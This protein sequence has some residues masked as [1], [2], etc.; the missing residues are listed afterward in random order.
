MSTQNTRSPG[1]WGVAA[2]ALLVLA[3]MFWLLRPAVPAEASTVLDVSAARAQGACVAPPEE[4]RRSHPDLLR[5]QR[6]VTVR[7]G[8]RGGQGSLEACVSCHATPVAGAAG[9]VRSVTGGPQQFCQGCHIQ[10][11]VQLDCFQCHA[12]VP[13]GPGH[14]ASGAVTAALAR[15]VA[16][17][18]EGAP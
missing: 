4:I 13:E 10:A 15:L 7:Q 11:A 5:H 1:G 8:V 17:R 2:L 9:P 6:D 18:P 16:N 14:R 12:A 3:A